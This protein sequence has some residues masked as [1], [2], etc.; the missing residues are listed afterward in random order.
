MKRTH[1]IF[2]TMPQNTSNDTLFALECQEFKYPRDIPTFSSNSH[3]VIARSVFCDE[4]ISKQL[5]EIASPREK[6]PGLA[7]IPQ[8]ENRCT[9][10]T[11]SPA[12]GLERRGMIGVRFISVGGSRAFHTARYG[13][14][15]HST[16][17]KCTRMIYALP[18]RLL[19]AQ[20]VK[21]NLYPRL[22]E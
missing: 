18:L 5:E 4:A 8:I 15:G 2:S 9:P 14:R 7:M 3:Y 21:V 20:V 13:K 19:H 17:L 6:R 1:V 12:C 16:H 10:G 11:N 22:E